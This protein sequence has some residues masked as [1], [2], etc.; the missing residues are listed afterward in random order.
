MAEKYKINY[1][2]HHFINLIIFFSLSLRNYSRLLLKKDYL[3]YIDRYGKY[4][5]VQTPRIFHDLLVVG[6]TSESAFWSHRSRIAFVS[7]LFRNSEK[8]RPIGWTNEASLAQGIVCVSWRNRNIFKK[9]RMRLARVCSL[10]AV[11][12]Y[13]VPWPR[14]AHNIA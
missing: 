1:I 2:S 6:N 4:R 13:N 12:G 14:R 5:F 8:Q 10:N 11:T 7:T 3:R 9:S